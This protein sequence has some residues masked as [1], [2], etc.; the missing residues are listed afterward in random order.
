MLVTSRTRRPCTQ[1]EPFFVVQ[2]RSYA[3]QH[4]HPKSNHR[5]HDLKPNLKHNQDQDQDQ[6]YHHPR[7]TYETSRNWESLLRR[8]ARLS[9]QWG[10]MGACGYIWLRWQL[11][12]PRRDVAGA[13]YMRDNFLT[14]ERNLAAGRWWTLVSSA[15]SHQDIWHLLPNMVSFHAFV[16]AAWM[17]GLSPL[18]IAAVG[19]ASAVSCSC[20]Q[21]AD[22][23]RKGVRGEALGAS[24]LVAGLGGYVTVLAPRLSFFLFFIPVPVPLWVLTPGLLAWDMYNTN[25][26]TSTVGHAGHVGGTVCGLALG[27]A[28]RA[29][30]R[31]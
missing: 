30:L 26:F 31:F 9:L 19:V 6:R 18:S 29:L 2:S 24:G 3:S 14:S 27:L 23:R 16:T 7:S 20:A 21:L 1:F 12:N 10:F 11:H 15:V 25:S 13:R 22:W 5:L 28:R 8:I 4:H 17:V